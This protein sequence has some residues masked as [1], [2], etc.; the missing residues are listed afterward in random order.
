MP[1]ISATFA[2][3]FTAFAVLYLAAARLPRHAL[4]A[5]RMLL[6]LG[7]LV[8]YAAADIRFLPFLLWCTAVTYIAG[9]CCKKRAAFAAFVAADLLP[10]LLV[11]YGPEGWLFPLGI[12][13]FTFQSIAYIA[14]VHAQRI[15]PEK[16]LLS[17]ALL[18]GFFPTLS[19]GPIQRAPALLPQLRRTHGFSYEDCTD[20]MKLFAWGMFKKLCVAGSIAP[21]VNFVYSAGGIQEQ[22]AL[23]ML[24][25]TVLYSFQIYADFSGYSDMAAG[26][27]RIIGFDAGKN[28][29]HPYLAA[30]TGE[31][32]RRWHI[33]L[34][35]W[36]RDYVYIP[37]GGS[38]VA[39]PRICVNLL[40][41][42]LVSGLWHG[43]SWNFVLWG[44]LHGLYQCAGRLS[45][46]YLPRLRLPAP[47]RIPVT[48]CLVTFSWIFFRAGS[49]DDAILAVRKLLSLPSELAAFPALAAAHGLKDA[50]WKTFS[51]V[52]FQEGAATGLAGIAVPLALLVCAEIASR[53]EGGLALVRRQPAAIRW[54]AYILLLLALLDTLLSTRTSW[55]ADFIYQNF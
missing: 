40:L 16:N 24:T 33:S 20:G 13:F 47:A 46:T 14:D 7:G 18:T 25:A 52:V 2:V 11:K 48:F 54:A 6:L 4:P 5:Q 37:L 21:Y 51:L 15:P 30:S 42:F 36:L 50:L 39:L 34:S 19:S 53:N 17:V 29:D 38:R 41:T 23:A 8:F 3:F 49:L 43:S 27:A 26:V 45:R 35:S 10:L 9:R 44:L 32:W 28:F 1:F 31:F 55:S 22:S 12:S